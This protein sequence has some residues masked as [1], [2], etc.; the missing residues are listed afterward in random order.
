MGTVGEICVFVNYSPKRKKMLGKLT[1]NMKGTFDP[2]EQQASK[3]NNPCV[4]RWTVR[5]NCLKKIIDNYE[6]LQKLWKESLKEK[7]DAETKSRIIGCKKQMESFKFYF[8]LQLG[9]KLYAHTDNLS[10]T[11]QQEKMSVIKGKSLADLN[12]QTLGGILNDRDYNLFY[13]S[14]EKSAG[15]IKAVSKP[16]LPQKRN[17]PNYSILQ[18]VE[19]HKSEELHYPETVHAFFKAIYNE[20]IDIIINSIQDRFEQPGF[21]VFGQ[22]E[23]FFLKSVKRDDHSDEIMTVESTFRGDYYHD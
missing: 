20:A 2:D 11:L 7:L 6:P 19:G 14:V 22:V 10:K 1:K 9:C 16:T 15:K 21:K 17:T 13:E 3:L 12:L 18:F 4:T 23:H 5:A 8:G